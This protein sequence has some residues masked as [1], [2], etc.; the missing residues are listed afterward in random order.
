MTSPFDYPPR[1]HI[2]KHGP[3][4]YARRA[5]YRRWLRDEFS[6]RCVYCLI[7]E[8]W[9]LVR[10]I[11]GVEHFQP[12]AQY[13]ELGNDYDNLLYACT[14]CNLAKADIVVPDPL[15]VFLAAV[16]YVA[17]NG[18][19]RTTS[20]EA[21]RLIELL[22]LNSDEYVEFRMLWLGIIALAKK[23]DRD[24]YIQLMGYPKNLPDLRRL[25]PPGG[26]ARSGGIPDCHH[27]MRR[28]GELPE[29]Y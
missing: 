15:Q 26:N 25:N 13:P 5:G 16:L 20:P 23:Y 3:R 17:E 4:G 29:T 11:F 27:A 14:S 9:G 10:G 22:G 28:R 2:R 24:L 19:L 7:R 18:F 6:F 8:Q 12:I 1:P 21:E